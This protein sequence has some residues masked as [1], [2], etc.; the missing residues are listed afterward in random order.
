MKVQDDRVPVDRVSICTWH[1]LIHSINWYM[2]S[3]DL[4]PT[5]QYQWSPYFSLGS[6]YNKYSEIIGFFPLP[7]THDIEQRLKLRN[8][9]DSR[10]LAVFGLKMPFLTTDKLINLLSISQA[11]ISLYTE[12]I[13]RV[14][15]VHLFMDISSG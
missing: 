11:S 13:I 9:I 14:Y 8:I 10:N 2:V 6:G 15:N 7:S 1:Q 12:R 3:I 4:V 5:D